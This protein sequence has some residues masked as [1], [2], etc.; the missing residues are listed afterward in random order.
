MKNGK[1]RW[2]KFQ[3]TK[4][5]IGYEEYQEEEKTNKESRK[6]SNRNYEQIKKKMKIA[7]K[8]KNC[9]KED[10]NK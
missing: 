9:F 8:L 6:R 5:I 7:D 10:S 1:D 4:V 3:N 2:K